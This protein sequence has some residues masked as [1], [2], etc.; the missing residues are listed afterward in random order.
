MKPFFTLA[1]GPTVKFE[2]EIS[3]KQKICMK[4]T[5]SKRKQ[6]GSKTVPIWSFLYRQVLINAENTSL[7]PKKRHKSDFPYIQTLIL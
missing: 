4:V 6:N 5:Q 1:Q 2:L 7:T 3:N